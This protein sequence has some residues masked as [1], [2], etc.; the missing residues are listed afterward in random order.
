MSCVS[1]YISQEASYKRQHIRYVFFAFNLLFFFLNSKSKKV[2]I[3][4]LKSY[5]SVWFSIFENGC[6]Q[7]VQQTMK[8]VVDKMKRMKKERK[9]RNEDKKQTHKK[10]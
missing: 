9:N 3:N 1:L 10:W 4:S 5:F 2:R 6:Q 8:A 7:R